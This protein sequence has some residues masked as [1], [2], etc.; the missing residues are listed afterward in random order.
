MHGAPP[1]RNANQSTSTAR[2]LRK[3]T[4]I[5][6]FVCKACSDA[7]VNPKSAIKPE[8]HLC[9]QPLKQLRVDR[10]RCPNCDF[11]T[12]GVIVAGHLVPLRTHPATCIAP[13]LRQTTDPIMEPVDE[14]AL[15]AS[16]LRQEILS[17]VPEL[18]FRSKSL[19]QQHTVRAHETFG[20]VA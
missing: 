11:M 20:T 15:A 14:K 3:A 2:R 10:F 17:A 7:I 12:E 18:R 1:S 16:Q 13:T 19:V 8:R 6:V 4:P 5:D 9:G